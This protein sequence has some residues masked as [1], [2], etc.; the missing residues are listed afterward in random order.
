MIRS[1]KE[2]SSHQSSYNSQYEFQKYSVIGRNFQTS[3]GNLDALVSLKVNE[4]CGAQAFGCFAENTHY[5][6]YPW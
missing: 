2:H 4:P 6:W 3:L 5:D 1:S